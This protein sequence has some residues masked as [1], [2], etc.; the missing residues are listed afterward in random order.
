MVA[1]S[2][3]SVLW[4]VCCLEFLVHRLTVRFSSTVIEQLFKHCKQVPRSAV[5]YFYF[6]F[7]DAGKRDAVSLVRSVVTQ[8]LAIC[9]EIPQ[10][11]LDLYQA[12]G[13]GVKPAEYQ[14]LITT[15][16]DMIPMFHSAYLVFDALDESNNC[17]EVI[18]LIHRIQSWKVSYLHLTVTSRQL[19][20]IEESLSP[21]IT[22]KICLHDSKLNG[23]IALYIA[24]KLKNDKTLAKWPPEIRLQI[25]RKLLTEDGG[26]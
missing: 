16:H 17:E 5:V 7:N 24:D 15:L 10:P 3:K 6:D 21:L 14:A 11:L 2:G 18:Q 23:D 25:Q 8:L 19:P 1:G 12:H 13:N 22:D 4:S 26:M 20:E 9:E